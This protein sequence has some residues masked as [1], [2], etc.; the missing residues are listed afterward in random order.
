[1]VG[2]L[3]VRMGWILIGVVGF[4]AL[5]CVV[6]LQ[7]DDVDALA[8]VE[9]GM[10]VWDH[11][12]RR[13]QGDQG[14]GVQRMQNEEKRRVEGGAQRDEEGEEARRKGLLLLHA[15]LQRHR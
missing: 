2:G 13:G 9:A 12:E 10:R 5:T 15:I 1:M 7:R 3:A 6:G 11:G 8:G 14:I 4:R